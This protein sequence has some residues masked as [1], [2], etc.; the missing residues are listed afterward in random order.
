MNPSLWGG[1]APVLVSSLVLLGDLDSGKDTQ[2]PSQTTDFLFTQIHICSPFQAT[3]SHFFKDAN[4]GDPF[5][6]LQLFPPHCQISQSHFNSAN[7]HFQLIVIQNHVS[8]PTIL[9]SFF[10]FFLKSETPFPSSSTGWQG[11]SSCGH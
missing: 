1:D 8:D 11:C 5:F 10:L 6:L 9:S 4:I 2:N 3:F 7:K